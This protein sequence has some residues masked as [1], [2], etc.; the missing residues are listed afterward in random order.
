ML[1]AAVGSDL[2][3]FVMFTLI[4]CVHHAYLTS[5]IVLLVM[6]RLFIYSII[7]L[8][9]NCLKVVSS[10][11]VSSLA[12]VARRSA[13]MFSIASHEIVDNEAYGKMQQ[14]FNSL[15]FHNLP[16]LRYSRKLD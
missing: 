8:A 7:L 6:G 10:A 13:S 1:S 11:D 16:H 2:N 9:G 15:T 4:R 3:I 5:F 14:N 12:S